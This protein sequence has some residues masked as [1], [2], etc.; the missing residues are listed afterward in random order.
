LAILKK[1]FCFEKL[2]IFKKFKI[3]STINHHTSTM[4]VSIP[5]FT[6]VKQKHVGPYRIAQWKYSHKK[7]GSVNKGLGKNLCF[8]SA[9]ADGAE[10]N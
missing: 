2:N 4:S 3:S 10:V 5:N 7:H 1:A 8:M 6:I 9:E